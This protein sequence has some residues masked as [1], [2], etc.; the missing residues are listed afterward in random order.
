MTSVAKVAVVIVV[1]VVIVDGVLFLEA[2][3]CMRSCTWTAARPPGTELPGLLAG[4]TEQLLDRRPVW[5]GRG[6]TDPDRNWVAL[7]RKL[8][9][10]VR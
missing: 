8:V 7:S 6:G 2:S 9:N 1:I 3:S 4:A 10:F 5:G